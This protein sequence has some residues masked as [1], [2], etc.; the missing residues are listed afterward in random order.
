M[1]ASYPVFKRRLYRICRTAMS[2]LAALCP[3][4]FGNDLFQLCANLGTTVLPCRRAVNATDNGLNWKG[5][6]AIIWV[7]HSVHRAC[8]THLCATRR[9]G[10]SGAIN[11]LDPTDL[12]PRLKH[13]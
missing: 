4:R 9:S 13:V 5:S 7:L 3:T 11:D 12:G 2:V 8:Q 6:L 10:V 1:T